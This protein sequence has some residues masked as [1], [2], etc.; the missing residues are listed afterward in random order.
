[1]FAFVRDLGQIHSDAEFTTLFTITHLQHEVRRIRDE[2]DQFQVIPSLWKHFFEKEIQ[3]VAFF[4]NDHKNAAV[5]ADNLDKDI[6]FF[7]I[8]AGG[9]DYLTITSLF[10]R[11]TFG[12]LEYAGTPERPYIFINEL[13]SDRGLGYLDSLFS[14]FPTLLHFDPILLSHALAPVLEFRNMNL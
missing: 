7:S 3:A 11:Q 5:A 9:Y 13:H 6:E 8:K 2:T 14:A 4:H 12:D 1:M 10:L